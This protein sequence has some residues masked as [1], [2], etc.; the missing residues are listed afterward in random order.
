MSSPRCL[1]PFLGKAAEDDEDVEVQ[2]GADCL[3]A[4]AGGRRDTGGITA[5]RIVRGDVLRLETESTTTSAESS[6]GKFVDWAM[7][8]RS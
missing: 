1:R 5:A 3:Q 7:K 2:R 4:A 6:C 8:T